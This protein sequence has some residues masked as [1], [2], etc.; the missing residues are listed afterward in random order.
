MTATPATPFLEVKDVH[1]AYGAIKAVDGITF[2]VGPGEIV[3]VIGPNGSG[4]TTLFNSI[5]G[6]IKPTS[7]RVD[8]CGE[9]I[10]GM[11]P[12]ELSRR[13]VGRTFQTLQVFVKLSVRDNLI[14]AAQEFRGKLAAR[15][16]ASP[17]AGLGEA[18]DRMIEM[19]RLQHV[20]HLPAGSLS[21]GQQKLIDIAMAFMP[22][23][24]LVLLDEPCAGVNPSLV[25]QLR[26]LLVELNKTQGGSFVVIEHNMDFI[27]RLCPHVICMVEGRVLA[28]GPPESVQSN[29]QVLEAY[30]GN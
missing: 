14:V 22:E 23:P 29:R 15:L 26:E 10:T 16:F 25:D 18:A 5:L 6:Q 9:D 11:S 3:G 20:A 2:N 7:G 4:K 21:Y 19:F 28:E 27:M 30:L 17:D 1:K 13:G 12:L 24:R 8:F